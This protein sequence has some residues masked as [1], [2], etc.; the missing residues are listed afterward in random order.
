M[1]MESPKFSENII[2]LIDQVKNYVKLRINLFKLNMTE[3][4]ATLT[5]TLLISVIFFIIFL[6]FTL[7]LSL[8]FIFWFREYIGAAY[9]GALI[10][11]GFY[12]LLGIVVFLLRDKLF[13][14]RVVT[15]I[16]KIL[17]EEENENEE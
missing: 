11:A 9:I 8:A 12:I 13:L 3:K 7:F 16:S 14:N 2:D 1:N 10:V 15:Q 5:T 17:L 4:M 6:F